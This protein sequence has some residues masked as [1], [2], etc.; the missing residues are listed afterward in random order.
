MNRILVIL[1]A[2]AG[3]CISVLAYPD[4]ALSVLLIASISVPAIVLI[5]R[6]SEN[7]TFLVNVFLTAL[8][9]RIGLGVIIH[10]FDL[11]GVF[12]PDAYGY[13]NVG[14]RLVEIWMG[15]PVPND[16]VT[17]RAMNLKVSGWGMPYLTFD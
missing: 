9:L 4:G 11:R 10:V 5:N 14:Q 7:N 8:L 15:R 12:G 2:L 3:L 6:Y 17:Y 16:V 1:C 13:N